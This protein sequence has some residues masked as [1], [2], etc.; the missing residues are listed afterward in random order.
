MDFATLIRCGVIF[1]VLLTTFGANMDDNLLA[2]LGIEPS[3]GYVLGLA[4]I[5][6]LLLSERNAFVVAAVVLF[7]LNTN[8][9]AEFTL[10]LGLDRDY[11]A[12]I[13]LALLFQ[14][15]MYRTMQLH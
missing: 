3:Y 12:G 11:Y 15:V 7:S 4:L 8:M 1:L 14:P 13:M 5:F 9:P 10:N 6:S 2:R